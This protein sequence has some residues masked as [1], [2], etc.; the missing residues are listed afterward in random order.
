MQTIHKP[1]DAKKTFCKDVRSEKRCGKV[2]WSF[3]ISKPLQT[4]SNKYNLQNHDYLCDYAQYD[5]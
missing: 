2:F 4:M 5:H 3:A 1:K